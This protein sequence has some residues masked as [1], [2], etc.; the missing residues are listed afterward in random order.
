ML[1]SKE[2]CDAR[3]RRRL[4]GHRVVEALEAD[5]VVGRF[6]RAAPGRAERRHGTGDAVRAVAARQLADAAEREF[7]EGAVDEELGFTTEH[8]AVVAEFAV[9]S[10]EAVFK[11]ETHLHAVAEVFD[12]LQAEAGAGLHALSHF[13]RIR[14]GRAVV[15]VHVRVLETEV[16]HAVERDIGSHGGAGK[17]AEH[18]ESSKSLLHDICLLIKSFSP[19]ASENKKSDP[20]LRRSAPP[21]RQAR[22]SI[23]HVARTSFSS[24][25]LT[26]APPSNRVNPYLTIILL[27]FFIYGMILDFAMGLFVACMQRLRMHEERP[28]PFRRERSRGSED[29]LSSFEAA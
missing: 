8:A 25:L 16:D 1:P 12:A 28:F 26:G 22:S 3:K 27:L 5:H 10:V 18:S 13:E 20:A 4:V 11:D 7:A 15:V 24:I 2:Y 14:I 6:D 21:S 29:P 17:S 23:V 9:V 19:E